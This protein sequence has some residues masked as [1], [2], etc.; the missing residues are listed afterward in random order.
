MNF[1][2]RIKHLVVFVKKKKTFL[3]VI[4]IESKPSADCAH[5]WTRLAEGIMNDLLTTML[6]YLLQQPK[7]LQVFIQA[8]G[9]T[10]DCSEEKLDKSCL[11][12]SFLIFA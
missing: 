7:I 5:R 4:R 6:R 10:S 8:I 11:S 9:L 12:P 2:I 3:L 1:S